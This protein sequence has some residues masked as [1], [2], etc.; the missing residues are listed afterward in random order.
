MTMLQVR[1]VVGRLTFWDHRRRRREPRWSF[2]KTF[3]SQRTNTG[4]AHSHTRTYTSGHVWQFV[5]WI[6][7]TTTT[8]TTTTA[9]TTTQAILSNTPDWHS[10]ATNDHGDGDKHGA[11]PPVD[12]LPPTPRR[13]ACRCSVAKSTSGLAGKCTHAIM[14]KTMTVVRWWCIWCD[15]R[16]SNNNNTFERG[17]RGRVRIVPPLSSIN[18]AYFKYYY[19]ATIDCIILCIQSNSDFFCFLKVSKEFLRP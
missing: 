1:T 6:M 13:R 11:L 17:R 18:I 16:R 8:T 5:L 9:T 4:P 15:S 10:R 3:C 14:T 2:R 19:N 12:V 7:T